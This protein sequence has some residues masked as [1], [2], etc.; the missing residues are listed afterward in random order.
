MVILLILLNSQLKVLEFVVM[1]L[2]Q[3]HKIHLMLSYI[4]LASKEVLILIFKLL[5]GFLYLVQTLQGFL[6]LA[7]NKLKVL[8][9]F[10]IDHIQYL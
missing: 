3:K 9:D 5:G 6:Y 4:P 2:Q 1:L 8:N 7:L 10:A